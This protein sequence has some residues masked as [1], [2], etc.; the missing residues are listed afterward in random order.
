MTGLNHIS[1]KALAEAWKVSEKTILR[2]IDER[3]ITKYK[4]TGKL[5]FVRVD[6]V[7]KLIEEHKV[8][9]W[10]TK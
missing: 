8:A 1:H 7:N 5:V 2:L 4:V 6:D 9:A 3:G 10:E